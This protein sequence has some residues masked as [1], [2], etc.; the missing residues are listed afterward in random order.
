[1]SPSS[2]ASL[3]RPD[4]R[5]NGLRRVAWLLDR[6][7]PVAGKFRIG[8][9]PIIGLLPGWGDAAGVLLSFYVIYQAARLGTPSTVLL[10]MVGNVA[11]ESLVG[12]IPV[13][14]DLFDAAWQANIRNVRLTERHYRP[15]ARP[16]SMARLLVMGAACL[17]L[18]L[19]AVVALA[20]VILQM[21]A[22]ALNQLFA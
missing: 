1:M 7:I 4:P 20:A 3:D 6:S 12:T 10:R 22:A 11:L 9:D 16:K 5:F 14:G 18:L 19:V 13:F 21:L 15:D 8:L 17:G 2:V